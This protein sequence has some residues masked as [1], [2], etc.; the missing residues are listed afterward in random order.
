[1]KST[2]GQLS[3]AGIVAAIKADPDLNFYDEFNRAGEDTD[4]WTSGGDAGSFSRLSGLSVP[5]YWQLATGNVIDN[6]RFIHGDAVINNKY[7]TPFE[8]GYTT[9][10]Y[11]ARIAVASIV[12]ISATI[13]LFLQPLEDYAEPAT[14]CAHFL[15]D[16]AITNTFRARTYDAAEQETDTLVALDTSYHKFVMIWTRTSV[17]FYIDDVLVATHATQVPEAPMHL[18]FLLRTEAA[19]AKY[20]QL[21]S[22]HV[23]IS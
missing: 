6:D 13:G 23:E 10:T 21:Q 5:T 7:F 16:P 18:G 12:D 11:E 1:M 22:V 8:L 17:A 4:V 14:R 20:M 2:P 9:I 19:A 3:L 15:M